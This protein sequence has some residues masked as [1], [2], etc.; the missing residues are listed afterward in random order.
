T[1]LAHLLEKSTEARQIRR[2]LEVGESVYTNLDNMTQTASQLEL[3]LL[4]E[5]SAA[6]IMVP[7]FYRM[8]LM[9][10]VEVSADVVGGF[11]IETVMLLEAFAN[12]AAIAIDNV[13]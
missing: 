7:I 13:R 2:A 12:Q 5:R 4:V 11:S 6:I 9:G 8:Q 3:A 10:V 1:A